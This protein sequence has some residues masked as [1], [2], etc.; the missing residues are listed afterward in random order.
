VAGHHAAGAPPR[1][2]PADLIVKRIAP[3]GVAIA[4]ALAWSGCG[5]SPPSSCQRPT[6]P[7]ATLSG[8]DRRSPAIAT[9]GAGA[10]IV[11]WESL[12]GLGIEATS[13]DAAA[14]GWQPPVTISAAAAHDVSVAMDPEGG[15]IA[16]WQRQPVGGTERIE[17]ADRRPG[18]AWTAPTVVSA[19][20][21]RARQPVAGLDG[22][23]DAIVVWRRDTTGDRA[24]IEVTERAAGGGWTAP[25]VLSGPDVRARRPRLAV[26][27]DGAAVVVWEERV[28]GVARIGAASRLPDGTWSPPARVAGSVAESHEP[29]VAIGADGHATAVW[30]GDDGDGAGVFAADSPG[31]GSWARPQLLAHGEAPPR[32]VPRPGRADTGA[33]V[34]A[35]PD[36]RTVAAWTLYD[37]GAD[38]VATATGSGG[39]WTP[40][41]RISHGSVAGGVQVAALAGGGAALA[42]E[43]LDGGLIRARTTRVDG[44]RNGCVD[45]SVARSE[46]GGVRVAGGAVPLVAFVDL[47]RS[48]VQV[49]PIP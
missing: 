25:R 7:P 4:A 11:A 38:V 46:T 31:D 20:G 8:N 30:I 14:Q 23:G 18:G 26:A 49:A 3:A 43:E 32:E 40:A 39:T 21:T 22:R 45:L 48:R 34:A 19:A 13:R 28:A 6:S 9:D 33:D 2:G 36:G 44:A 47:N 42:W 17:V 27:P 41:R 35:L 1:G 24:V 12:A 16:A 5:S 37:A 29:D 15:A 10:A